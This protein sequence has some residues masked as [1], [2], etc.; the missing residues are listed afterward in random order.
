[1]PLSDTQNLIFG[2][3]CGTTDVTLL[4]PT[5]YW[6]NAQQQKLPFTLS[7]SVLYRGYS[8]NVTNNA[9]W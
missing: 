8:A 4:Q 1:M 5:N 6:K 3:V 7:P 2:A 9:F